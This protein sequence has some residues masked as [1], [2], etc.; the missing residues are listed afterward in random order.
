MGDDKVM[1]TIEE[2]G[3]ARA[4]STDDDVDSLNGLLC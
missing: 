3:G 1:T 4:M 2:R